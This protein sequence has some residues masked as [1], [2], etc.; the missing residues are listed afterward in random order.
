MKKI[1]LMLLSVIMSL[2]LFS[3]TVEADTVV[4]IGE[5]PLDHLR[6]NYLTLDE[7]ND[8]RV[9]GE[10]YEVIGLEDETVF[11]VV[12]YVVKTEDEEVKFPIFL[13]GSNEELLEAESIKFMYGQTP[14]FTKDGVLN[15]DK[16][17]VEKLNEEG[18]LYINYELVQAKDLE[19][20][21]AKSDHGNYMAKFELGS[22]NYEIPVNVSGG[23]NPVL[24]G[25]GVVILGAVAALVVKK[26]RG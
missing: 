13:L 14:I 15:I 20:V 3:A 5:A 7:V 22:Q 21:K 9:D 4:T 26:A 24:I 12:D 2:V 11:T 23:A 25:L 18:K 6:E 8:I 10:N 19:I 16:K 17:E 1:S